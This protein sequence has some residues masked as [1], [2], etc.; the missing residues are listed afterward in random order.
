MPH[1]PISSLFLF[2]DHFLIASPLFFPLPSLF[3]GFFFDALPH[4]SQGNAAVQLEMQSRAA[5]G[6]A[7]VGVR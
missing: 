5:G 3:F 2:G 6:D 1:F 7:A 4:F